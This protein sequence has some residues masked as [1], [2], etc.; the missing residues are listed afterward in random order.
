MNEVHVGGS[1][2]LDILDAIMCWMILLR[3]TIPPAPTR[4]VY[5]KNGEVGVRPNTL[6]WDTVDT[7]HSST[8]I[9]GYGFG[10]DSNG[11][12]SAGL[13]LSSIFPQHRLESLQ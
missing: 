13:E 6:P 7:Y 9:L 10:W 4:H 1:L 2:A 5:V 11:G 8:L 3:S 12:S